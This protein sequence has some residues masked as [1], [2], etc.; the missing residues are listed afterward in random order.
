MKRL[1]AVVGAVALALLLAGQ[2][3][4]AAT[5]EWTD[6]AG[7]ATGVDVSPAGVPNA[8]EST[9]RPSEPEFDILKVAITSSADTLTVRATLA[10][11]GI[12]STGIG[13][14]FRLLFTHDGVAYD[15]IAQRSGD[16]SSNAFTTAVF[17]RVRTPYTSPETLA[18]GGCG[19]KYEPTAVVFTAKLASLTSGIRQYKKSPPL[20]AGTKLSDVG[21]L[22]QRQNA[23]AQ[24]SVD[25][26]RTITVDAARAKNPITL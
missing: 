22:A 3:A 24:R 11:Q 13:T 23:T 8:L 12:P 25:V 10:K 4:Q 7:D 2:P 20:A 19:V 6:P 15:L 9:P 1:T 26:G 17:L 21:V 18:C 16:V 14:V 5:T